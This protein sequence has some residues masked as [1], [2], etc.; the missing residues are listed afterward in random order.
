VEDRTGAD[1]SLWRV[2]LLLLP[3]DRLRRAVGELI[4]GEL[5]VKESKSEPSCRAELD[6]FIVG[7]ESLLL[8]NG[9]ECE[10]NAA[11]L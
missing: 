9:L 7:S 2:F 3:L 5:H 11:P 1:A 4:A 6:C 8:T 10:T